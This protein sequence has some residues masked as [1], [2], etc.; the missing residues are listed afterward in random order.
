MIAVLLKEPT[1]SNEPWRTIT[2]G[3]HVAGQRADVYLAHRYATWSRAQIVRMIRNGQIQSDQRV[4]KPASTLYL[5]EVLRIT[6]PEHEQRG[7]PPPFPAI[8][9]E[10]AHLV[11]VNKPAGMLAHPAGVGVEWTLVEL[12][13]LRWPEHQMDLA[14]RLDRDTSGVMVLTKDKVTNAKLKAALQTDA[15]QKTYLALATGRPDWEEELVDAPIGDR[16]DSTIRIRRGVMAGGLPAQS[17]FRV[18]AR[19]EAHT[20][21]AVTLHTGRTHQ[22]RIHLEHLGMPLLGDKMYGQ[23]DRIFLAHLESGATV[24]VRDAV[25]FPRHALHAW[26]LSIPDLVLPQAGGGRL[27]LEAPLPEDMQA[28]VDGTAPGWPDEG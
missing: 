6:L 17:T 23:P 7:P 21:M 25:G 15:V 5:G 13:R 27:E 24:E 28:V 10:D 20:L 19:L 11:V 3:E 26:R 8:L 2:I 16:T 18:I 14:H 12:A 22:I 1:V 9:H 4:L